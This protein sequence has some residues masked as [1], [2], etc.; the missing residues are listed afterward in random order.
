V[1]LRQT[2]EQTDR[3]AIVRFSLRQKTRSRRCGCGDVLVLQTLL[4]A[5]EVREASFPALDEPV[6][7]SDEGARAVGIPRGELLGDF[8]PEQFVDE[9]QQ[10]LRTLIDAK[11]EKGDAL[12]TAETFGEQAEDAGVRSSTSWRR[13]RRASRRPRVRAVGQGLLIRRASRR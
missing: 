1:L 12:D 13:S 5:D 8:D 4:W 7:I 3:T 6:K 10:E 9:Y 2:L 11:L